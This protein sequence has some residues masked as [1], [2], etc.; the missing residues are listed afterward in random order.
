MHS[1]VSTK[2]THLHPHTRKHWFHGLCEW[3]NYIE[4]VGRDKI[5]TFLAND[6][7]KST[8]YT[9]KALILFKYGW[10]LPSFSGDHQQDHQCLWLLLCYSFVLS[11]IACILL[12]IKL[13][14]LLL[15]FATSIPISNKAT[16][17]QI[18]AWGL[19]GNKPIFLNQELSND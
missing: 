16:L 12:G 13:L 14:L 7:F 8:N 6:T 9:K 4:Y 19:T 18:M 10:D 17:V 3:N 11:F 5:A 15:L 2:Q 1:Q